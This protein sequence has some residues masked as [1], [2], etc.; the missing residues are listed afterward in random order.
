[1]ADECGNHEPY[2]GAVCCREEHGREDDPKSITQREQGI[3]DEG[4]QGAL[5]NGEEAEGED[6][7]QDVVAEIDIEISLS[8]EHGAVV[9]DVVHAVCESQEHGH[10][11]GQ[12]KISWDVESRGEVVN[13]TL[14]IT[15]DHAG[16]EGEEG[17][18]QDGGEQVRLV[19][20]FAQKGASQEDTEL[21]EVLFRPESLAS[22]WVGRRCGGDFLGRGW[23][24]DFLEQAMGFVFVAPV[25]RR[26]AAGGHEL[27]PVVFLQN[28]VAAEVAERRFEHIENEFRAGCSARLAPA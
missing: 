3:S 19:A 8:H 16:E 27:P 24:L 7:C 22:A 9:D 21:A 4:K 1:M 25:V 14:G 17:G 5:D 10:D 28:D 18:F 23:L 12:E 26:V 2:C 13:G 20:E 6:F 15:Q 11:E